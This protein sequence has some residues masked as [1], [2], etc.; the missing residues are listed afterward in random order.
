MSSSSSMVQSIAILLLLAVAMAPAARLTAA[1]AAASP[2]INTTCAA[3]EP[4][5][6]SDYC[7]R[8]LSGDPAA[9][10][11]TDVRGVA[12][13]AANLTAVKAARTLRVISYLVDDLVICRAKYSKMVHMLANVTADLGAGRFSDASEI[14]SFATE[15]PEM[16]DMLLMEGKAEKDPIS[17]ETGEDDSLVHLTDHII[18][19]LQK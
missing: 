6:S 13:A 5:D 16:C 8:V 15:Y 1:A 11:A 4:V 17:Q 19:L 2:L 12:A 18:N 3:L 9:A 10:A 14:M 7:V